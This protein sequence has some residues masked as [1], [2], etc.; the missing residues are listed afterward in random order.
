MSSENDVLIKLIEEQWTQARHS[1]E[2]RATMTNF[3]IVVDAAILG[4]IVD[5][6]FTPDLLPL[7]ILLA[8]LGIY[9]VMFCCKLYER[10]SSHTNRARKFRDK[11]DELHPNLGIKS[12]LREADAEHTAQFKWVERIRL[13]RLWMILHGLIG[14][15]G[16]L[17]SVYLFL[18]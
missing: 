15:A 2:Q 14:A 4:F 9:G 11:L 13:N 8:A 5:R 7:T 16:L 17:M 3:V 18:V 1:E 10:F 6:A 12:L